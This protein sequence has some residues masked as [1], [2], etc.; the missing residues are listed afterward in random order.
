VFD[1]DPVRMGAGANANARKKYIK[2]GAL[3]ISS[4]DLHELVRYGNLAKK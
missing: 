3:I 1:R 4:I 2:P